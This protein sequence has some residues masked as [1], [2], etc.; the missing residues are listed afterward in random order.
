MAYWNSPT[1]FIQWTSAALERSEETGKMES[2]VSAELYKMWLGTYAVPQAGHCWEYTDDSWNPDGEMCSDRAPCCRLLDMSDEVLLMVLELLDPF[3]LLKLGGAC[4]TLYRISNTD[5]LWARHC[6]LVFGSGFRNGCTDYTPKEAFKLLYMWGKLYKTLPCNRQ[7]QDLLFSGLPLK[8]YWIQWLTLEEMVPLPPVQLT[9][10]AIKAIWGIN[11]DQLDEKHKVTDESLEDADNCLY[12]Y[13]WKELHN[14]AM[15]YH[16]DF[17][18][19]QSHVLQKMSMKCHEDLEWLYCQFMHYRFQWL[20]SYW[21]FGLSKSCAKQLQRIF[22]WWKRF[23]KRKVSSWGSSACDVEYLASLHAIT[24]D[25]WNG[26]LACGDENIGIQTV[27]NYFSMC[28]SLLAWI[29]GRKWGRFKQKKV[30]QDTLDGVYRMLKAEMQVSVVN[31]EQFWAAAKVQMMRI[32]T[33]EETAG[34]YVNWKLIDSLPCYRLYMTFGDSFY[35]E[36]IKGFLTRKQL[37]SNWLLKEENFWVRN[38]LPE[39]LFYLLEYDTK[40]YEERLHGDTMVAHLTR[41]IWLYLH[42]GHQLYIDAM[43]GFVYE[44]A[45]ASFASQIYESGT[46][47]PFYTFNNTFFVDF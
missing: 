4:R 28:R 14:M 10:Q 17:T 42:S 34:N 43:K 20:F 35:L 41:L 26:K 24:D 13:D 27:E 15:K 11:K 3:S 46:I 16:G 6:R 1:D 47:S 33:L 5:S 29:L 23:D 25:Y 18:K 37:I 12:R 7:L 19:L 39:S 21:L 22:L 45:Y 32:C 36:H 38:L 2:E 44:C 31:H 40:I 9:D 30:Y 8:R